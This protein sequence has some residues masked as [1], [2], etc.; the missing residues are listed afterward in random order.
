MFENKCNY[1][2]NYKNW[3]MINA[4]C[5]DKTERIIMRNI[6]FKSKYML[7]IIHHITKV[8]V[9]CL[10]NLTNLCECGMQLS[11]LVNIRCST[12]HSIK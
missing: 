6:D 7:A 4:N 3:P 5:T 8:Q 1:E 11:T 2:P 9:P 12:A 10:W